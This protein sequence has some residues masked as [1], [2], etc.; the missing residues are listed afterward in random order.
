MFDSSQ[1]N[2]RKDTGKLQRF[3]KS[4]QDLRK[5]I[6]RKP[7]LIRRRSNSRRE[8]KSITEKNGLFFLLYTF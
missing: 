4:A 3:T 1:V 6:K 8:K 5:W 7:S 2:I